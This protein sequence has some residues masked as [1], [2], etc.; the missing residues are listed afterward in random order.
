[1]VWKLLFACCVFALTTVSLADD[2]KGNDNHFGTWR[3]VAVIVDGKEYPIAATTIL[4]SKPDGWAVTVDGKPYS[5]GTV[6]ADRSKSPVSA[7]VTFTEGSLAGQTL[8]QISKVEGDVLI[9]N[10]AAQRPTEFTSKAGSGRT[11]SVWIR[12]K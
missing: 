9:A 2:G 6:K 1:M 11:L 10:I 5:K 4:N 12:V 7:E 8:Q 3:Q